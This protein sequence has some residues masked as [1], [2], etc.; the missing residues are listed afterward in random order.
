MLTPYAEEIVRDHQC[1]FR[2]NRSTTDHIFALLSNTLNKMG[3]NEPVHQLF[4]DFKKAYYSV[5]RE[6]LYNILMEMGIPMQ[7]VRLITMCLNETYRTGRVGENL[8]DM[9][10]IRNALKKGDVSSPLLFNFYL[11]YAIGRVQVN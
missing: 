5:K 6:V 9:F 11:E 3:V 2:R 4:I 1:G 8:S 10:S 7:L